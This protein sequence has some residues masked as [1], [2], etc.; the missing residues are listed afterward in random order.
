MAKVR[1][2]PRMP[3]QQAERRTGAFRLI[4]CRDNVMLLGNRVEQGHR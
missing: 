2:L 4:G 1:Q 3:P